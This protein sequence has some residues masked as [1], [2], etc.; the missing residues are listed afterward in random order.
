MGAGIQPVLTRVNGGNESEAI[1]INADYITVKN[2]DTTTTG[3]DAAILINNNHHHDIIS[4]NV[5]HDAGGNGIST[6]TDDYITVSHNVVYGNAKNTTLSFNSGISLLGSFDID[7]NTGVKMIV[8]SN[9][10]Y[11]N[12]NAPSCSTPPMPCIVGATATAAALL[13]MTRSGL[14]STTFPIEVGR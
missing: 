14:S 9:I 6:F 7:N 8:D 13:S 10:V 11:G 2:F 3:P 5:V 1:W 4:Y 12:S